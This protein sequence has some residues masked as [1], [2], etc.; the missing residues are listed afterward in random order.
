MIEKYVEKTTKHVNPQWIREVRKKAGVSLRKM[1]D[2]LGY[3]PAFI[4][5]VELGRRNANERIVEYID[6]L[7]K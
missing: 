6:S 4:S 2:I 7:A 3:S 1:A 5:D